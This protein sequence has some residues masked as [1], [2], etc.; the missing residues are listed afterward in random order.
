MQL[1]I[2]TVVECHLNIRG[3][4]EESLKTAWGPVTVSN[5]NPLSVSWDRDHQILCHCDFVGI[6]ETYCILWNS[7]YSGFLGVS[8]SDFDLVNKRNGNQAFCTLDSIWNTNLPTFGNL[9]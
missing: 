5:W 4:V 1:L 3:D 2:F 8:R 7:T 6:L 9:I